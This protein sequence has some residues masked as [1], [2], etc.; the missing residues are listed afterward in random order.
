MN[1]S[2]CST[3]VRT[4]LGSLYIHLYLQN[5][6]PKEK[7]DISYIIIGFIYEQEYSQKKSIVQR[8]G[9]QK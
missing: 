2:D 5:Y 6:K 3:A 7:F 9:K 4:R 1:L 8:R